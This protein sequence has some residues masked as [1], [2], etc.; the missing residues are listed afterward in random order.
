[1]FVWFRQRQRRPAAAC[2]NSVLLARAAGNGAAR[3]SCGGSAL[4]LGASSAAGPHVAALLR[5]NG[6]AE[7][8]PTAARKCASTFLISFYFNSRENAVRFI[9]P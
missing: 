5:A 8:Q 7:W 2:S 4:P 1:V 6:A 9:K 3:D